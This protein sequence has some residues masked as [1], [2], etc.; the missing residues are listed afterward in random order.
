MLSIREQLIH[1]TVRIECE[2]NGKVGTGTGFFF[3]FDF[4][5]KK[6]PGIITNKHVV[7]DVKKGRII[8]K[9]KDGAGDWDVGKSFSVV[10]ENFENSWI[11]HPEDDVDL[12]F[13]P[14]APLLKKMEEKKKA[15]FFIL[16][17]ESIFPS[18][19]EEKELGSLEEIVMVGYPNGIWDS[20]NNIPIVRKGITATPFY[21]DYE[22]REEFLID[23]ACFGGSSGSPVFLMNLGSY[24]DGGGIKIGNR[25]KFLGI[26]YAGPQYVAEGEIKIVNI[27]TLQ[28]PIPSISIPNNL[29]FVIKSKKLLGLKNLIES[30]LKEIEK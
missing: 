26:L 21:I 24:S 9:L 29:G 7:R 25:V 1:T 2:I 10:L 8:L 12:C 16:L 14:I 13:F 15:P 18:P 17:D 19:E 27:P 11:F 30:K 3:N 6:I 20:K 22:E 23:V 28:K 4:G 5:G